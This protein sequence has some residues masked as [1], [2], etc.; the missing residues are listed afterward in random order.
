MTDQ[1]QKPERADMT[2]MYLLEVAADGG[3][4]GNC[5][6]EKSVLNRAIAELRERR[7]HG[8]TCIQCGKILHPSPIAV[9]CTE[10]A[11]R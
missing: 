7:A 4:P 9:I 2:D 1:P 8:L 10:C 3:S 6:V 11:P 5:V